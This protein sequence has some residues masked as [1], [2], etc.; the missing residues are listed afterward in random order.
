[1]R[2]SLV[3]TFSLFVA[4]VASCRSSSDRGNGDKDRDKEIIDK[5]DNI[6]P[7][8]LGKQKVA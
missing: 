7:I 2:P 4:F 1:M 3:L 8:I 6:H 5:L